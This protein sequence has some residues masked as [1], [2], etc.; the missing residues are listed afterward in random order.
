MR[1]IKWAKWAVFGFAG[2]FAISVQARQQWHLRVDR[3]IASLNAQP[4]M[5]RDPEAAVL[6]PPVERFLLSAVPSE[7]APVRFVEL[8][9]A[10]DFLMSPPNGWKP[11]HAHQRFNVLSPGFVW[12]ARIAM[13]PRV[14]VFVRDAYVEGRGEMVA[15]VLAAYAVANESASSELAEGQL[16]RFLAEMMWFPSGLR[17]ENGVRWTPVDDHRAM[18]HLTD[19]GRTVS[20]QFTFN[21]A[22]EI[23]EVSS[24]AR[25]RA[26]AGGY[27]PTPW[28]VRC[29]DYQQRLGFRIPIAC[30]AE[31]QLPEGPLAYWRGKI[32]NVR[33]E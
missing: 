6:P 8:D 19:H 16:M 5:T 21:G 20:L 31:W 9:T 18:A 24:P 11:F 32:T 27:A 22:N 12:D 14:P 28:T 15:R 23:T 26:V 2:V 13:A 30:E 33:Y 4:V 3:L 7:R 29:W 10:G 1:I 25:L 17:P